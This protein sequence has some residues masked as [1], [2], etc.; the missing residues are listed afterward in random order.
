MATQQALAVIT[1]LVTAL[2]AAPDLD[3]VT[4]A[5]GWEILPVGNQ[6]LVV[7][8]GT[9]TGTEDIATASIEWP[10]MSATSR[11]EDGTIDCVAST[12]TG[13]QGAIDVTIARAYEIVGACEDVLRVN[14]A[15]F[16]EIALQAKI[17][18]T[19]LRILQRNNGY[20]VVVP[21]TVAYM[22]SV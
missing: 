9:G 18:E 11:T 2:R 3:G 17:V 15:L 7:I 6:E 5:K 21:F 19:R 1:G 16:A 8:A 20:A 10:G 22:S 14:P 4:V 13:D 12:W